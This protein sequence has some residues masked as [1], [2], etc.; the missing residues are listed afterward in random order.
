MMEHVNWIHNIPF[1][2]IFLAMFCGIITPL[3]KDGKTAHKVHALMVLIVAIMSA[4]LL[5][6]VTTTGE[7]FTFMM[8]HFP[9]PWGNELRAGPLEAMMALIFSVVMLLTTTGGQEFIFHD[10]VPEKQSFYF[11][12]LNALFGSMLALAYTNDIFTAYVFIEILTIASCAL[13]M[14]KGT[15]QAMVGTTHYLV[16]SLLGSGTILLGIS[17]LY[18]ITGHLLFPQMKEAIVQLV[19]TGQYTF[20]L[21]VVTGFVF[22][23]LAIKSALFPFHSML[24]GAYQAA[25]PTSSGVLSGL[26]LKSYIFL[27]IKL[28]YSVFSVDVMLQL[29]I[30][31]ILFVFGLAG[32]VMGLCV[33]YAGNSY[34]TY[35][36]LL[37]CCADWVYL[38][39]HRHVYQNCYGCGLLPYPCPCGDKIHAVPLLRSDGTGQRRQRTDLLSERRRTEKSCGRHRLYRRGI[40]HGRCAAVCRLYFQAVFRYGVCIRAG[41]NGSGFDCPW[42]QYDSER[43]VFPAFC[44][45]NLD[46]CQDRRRRTDTCFCFAGFWRLYHFVCADQ[47]R[48]G[49]ILSSIYRSH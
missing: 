22:I 1:F 30:I 8:G 2:S 46:T 45:R 13:I 49:R 32:M 19:A 27:A 16:I 43:N 17:I 41:E 7:S 38:H 47:Y 28:I 3:I 42:D 35:A 24:P 4:I 39:G 31:D 25:V 48:V 15:A 20:P 18:S 36:C 37:F 10:V 40:V 34:E 11:I 6:N 21:L 44:Y 33:R 23:G 5:V 14:A 29:K 26:V 9:A 12:M